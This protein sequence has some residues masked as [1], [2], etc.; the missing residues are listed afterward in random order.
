MIKAVIFDCGRV[1]L[2]DPDND[3]I[4]ADWAESCNL[5]YSLV[6]RVGNELL[7]SY[8]TGTLDDTSFWREFQSRTKL[9]EL[10]PEYQQFWTQIYLPL[11]RIDY[12]VLSLVQE[13]HQLGIKTPVLSNTIP[14][15]VRVNRN[16]NLIVKNVKI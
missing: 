2:H 8:Q 11:T 14:P 5:D 15:H 12:E 13:L 4:F 9:A 10:P 6:E 3:I 7:P 1:F 16:R